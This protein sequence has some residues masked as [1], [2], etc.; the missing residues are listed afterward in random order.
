MSVAYRGQLTTKICRHDLEPLRVNAIYLRF[1]FLHQHS[2]VEKR[3]DVA[4]GAG[5]AERQHFTSK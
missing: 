4:P 3:A 1:Q 2:C 5:E